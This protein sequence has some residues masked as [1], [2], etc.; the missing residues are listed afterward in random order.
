M[1]FLNVTPDFYSNTNTLIVRKALSDSYALI[2]F[3]AEQKKAAFLRQPF[4]FLVSVILGFIRA[5]FRNTY[6]VSLFFTQNFQIY[7]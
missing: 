5:L 6:V 4:D 3:Y 7:T 2:L 1:I